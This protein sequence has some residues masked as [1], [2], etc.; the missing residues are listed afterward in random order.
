MFHLKPLLP[1][2]I[3]SIES[4]GFEFR[5]KCTF[6]LCCI[7]RVLWRVMC[8]TK[9]KEDSAP[10]NEEDRDWVLSFCVNFECVHDKWQLWTHLWQHPA[11]RNPGKKSKLPIKFPTSGVAFLSQWEGFNV[12]SWPIRRVD[13][14][15]NIW[16]SGEV[17]Q[18][19]LPTGPRYHLS[20][21]APIHTF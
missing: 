2:L 17:Y 1:A 16:W 12:L 21:F 9:Q 7:S 3:I 8:D 14:E 19:T 10:C 15:I 4:P 18:I 6:S 13:T 5:T 11:Q 20:V